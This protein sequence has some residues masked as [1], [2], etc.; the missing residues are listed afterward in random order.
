MARDQHEEDLGSRLQNLQGPQCGKSIFY[1]DYYTSFANADQ[2]RESYP[3]LK[4]KGAEVKDLVFPLSEIWDEVVDH[5][6]EL[7]L[8]RSA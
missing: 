7:V 3:K 2:P 6:N 4:G 8:R 1:F 5:Q